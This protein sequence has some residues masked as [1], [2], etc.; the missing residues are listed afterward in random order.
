MR[1][2]EDYKGIV[3]DEVIASIHRKARRLQGKHILHINSTYQ[4]G[5]VAEMLVSLVPMMNDIGIDAGWRILHGT[6]D[7]FAVTKKFHNAL[8][9]DKINLTELKKQLYTHVNEDFSTYTHIDHDCVIIHD[10][11]PLALIKFYRKRQPWIWRCHIDLSNPNEELW[12]YLKGF[13]LRYDMVIFSSD[14]YKKKDLPVE[15]KLIY[16]A[17]D[18]LSLKNR[19]ISDKVISK[20]IRKSRIPTDKPIITQVSRMDPW[21][22]P[23]GLLEIYRQVKEDVDCRLLYCYNLATDDPESVEIYSRVYNQA[24]K[25]IQNGDVL[26]V[27][28][29]N[30]ILVNSIQ[31]FSDVI[32]QKSTRE[33]FSLTVTEALWKGKP[34]VASNIGGIPLQIKDGVNG[35][36]HDPDDRKG[37]AESIIKI[38]KA[39][40][41]GEEIGRNGKKI[42]RDNFLIT[43]LL[44][45]YLDLLNYIF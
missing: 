31:R 33:G 5:G 4:G 18:P 13:V 8:Q 24:R 22:D 39:P 41:I 45:D 38:L 34:V 29:N 27:M 12:D 23:L 14:K 30:D 36:L 11:Q 6:P 32:V 17:I 40:G 1:N 16:P 26:F 3:G 42:V 28:G 20:Y 10:P 19:E 25:Y 7:F 21:K 15:Q 43:R 9:G 2:L 35:F 44:S 37:Y